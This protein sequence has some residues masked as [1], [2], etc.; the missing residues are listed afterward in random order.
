MKFNRLFPALPL[1]LALLAGLFPAPAA[2]AQNVGADVRAYETL[3]AWIQDTGDETAALSFTLGETEMAVTTTLGETGT[4]AIDPGRATAPMAVNERTLLP[5]RAIVETLGGEIAY[6]GGNRVAIQ[7]GG[8]SIQ[9]EAGDTTIY[10]DGAPVELDVAPCFYEE[11]T[12]LP[13]RGVTEA[14]DCAVAWDQETE[15]VT[16]ENTYAARRLLVLARAGDRPALEET[17]A[18]VLDLGGGLFALSFSTTSAAAGAQET[19]EQAG[20]SVTADSAVQAAL[21]GGVTG[22]WENEATGLE[23][24]AQTAAGDRA[25]TVAVI[26]TGI[27]PAL[28]LF[29]GRLEEGFDFQEGHAGVEGDP[30]GHGT[31]VSSLVAAYTPENV[32]LLPIRAFAQSGTLGQAPLSILCAAVTFAQ[33][34]GADVANLSFTMG[35]SPFFDQVVASAVEG[36]MAVVA[37]AGN[38]GADTA[39]FSPARCEAAIVVAATGPDGRLA[40]FSNTGDRVD[41]SA[42]GVDVTG[43]RADGGLRTDSGTS[44][45]APLVSA[46]AAVLLSREALSPARLEEALCACTSPMAQSGGGAGILDLRSAAEVPE[47]TP[48]CSPAPTVTPTPMPTPSPGQE[49]PAEP[50]AAELTG[51]RWSHSFVELA[52]GEET[53]VYLRAH[54]VQEGGSYDVDVTA[55]AQLYSSDSSVVEVAPGGALLA[56]APG[57]A[58]L[59]F[60]MASASGVTL[61]EPLEVTVTAAPAE[62]VEVERVALTSTSLLM[63]PGES[64]TIT[65]VALPYEAADTRITWSTSNPAVASVKNGTIT[66]EGTGD[67]TVTARASNGVS[68]SCAVRVA[69]Y[70]SRDFQVAI[71]SGPSR[72]S[73]TEKAFFTLD[74]KVPAGVEEELVLWAGL[75]VGGEWIECLSLPLTPESQEV[76]CS[77]DEDQYASVASGEYILNF[78]LFYADKYYTGASIASTIQRL[79]LTD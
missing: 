79:T 7:A 72:V 31:F 30:N 10:V 2:G 65:A 13:V 59:N 56:K 61:P 5:A 76:V 19:L 44:F 69:G 62:E 43:L 17:G 64:T 24:F 39:L 3:S 22:G 23:A 6:Q 41:L 51:F 70:D 14:L 34:A 78:S 47:P 42:P 58:Y 75:Y 63:E 71:F 12:Y 68:A 54:Y 21:S 50:E 48:T 38:S 77:L 49:P 67:C 73:R 55:E 36:G 16:V 25:V 37:A 1:S 20:F 9:L 28:G 52:V 60:H 46:A 29:A 45:A 57:T 53:S 33:E 27:S 74:V 8:R 66:A 11:R 18:E 26:D 35:A 32:S 4:V 15:T 40:D